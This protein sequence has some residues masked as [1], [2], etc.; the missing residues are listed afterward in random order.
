MLVIGHRGC[1]GQYPENTIPAVRGAAPHVDLVEVD[2]VPSG[3]GDLV[4]FHDETLDRL[5]VT[6]GRVDETPVETLTDLRVDGSTATI[7][8]FETVVDAW[9][10]GVGMN[11]DLHDPTIVDRAL[12][13]VDGLG[14]RIVLSSTAVGAIRAAQ[15]HPTA[16]TTG[17]SFDSDPEAELARARELGVEFVHVDHRLCLQSSVI[18]RAHRQGCQV[19]AW[20]L[21]TS[22]PVET[23]RS[24]GVDAVTVDRWDIVG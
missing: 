5:T 3:S 14:E 8:R 11:L 9:P 4:V 13:I 10:S 15:T 24:R 21:A 17:Y 16:V 19:D 18:E 2:V 22:Q 7:P 6:S 12:D 1:A 20:T 23:L